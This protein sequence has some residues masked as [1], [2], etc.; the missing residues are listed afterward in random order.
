[1]FLYSDRTLEVDLSSFCHLLHLF[2]LQSFLCFK[3]LKYNF[4]HYIVAQ[5]HQLYCT[6]TSLTYTISGDVKEFVSFSK[7]ARKEEASLS[8]KTVLDRR[9]M[10]RTAKAQ[11]HEGRA[12]HRNTIKALETKFGHSPCLLT[13]AVVPLCPSCSC[14][15]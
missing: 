15:V 12:M 6:S 8:I 2:M 14:M 13:I 7:G 1:M 5:V 11:F 10:H 9:A 4:S 3:L